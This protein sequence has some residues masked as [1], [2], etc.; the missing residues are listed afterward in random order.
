MDGDLDDFL[1]ELADDVVEELEEERQ[2]ALEKERLVHLK[3]DEAP[4][5]LRVL[6][7]VGFLGEEEE[8]VLLLVHGLDALGDGELALGLEQVDFAVLE[9]DVE[10]LRAARLVEPLLADILLNVRVLLE[11]AEL[12]REGGGEE[13]A[14]RVAAAAE[15]ALFGHAGLVQLQ[16]A[17]EA[18]HEVLHAL[19]HAGHRRGR[20]P[21]VVPVREHKHFYGLLELHCSIY[22]IS[23]HN[24]NLY[25]VGRFPRD[26]DN[27]RLRS[28]GV[29]RFRMQDLGSGLQPCLS[30]SFSFRRFPARLPRRLPKL[31]PNK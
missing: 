20:R 4:E 13:A 19:R 18:R 31:R 10:V 9:Q 12:L 3:L 7:E 21:H 16:R 2:V 27:L 28:P 6:Q 23:R 17:R 15:K 11:A 24:Y 29:L 22:I 26:A 5:L 30:Y 1:Y 25:E 8:V 14:H